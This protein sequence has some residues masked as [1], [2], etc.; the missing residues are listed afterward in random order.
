MP[1]YTKKYKKWSLAGSKII[2][3]NLIWTITTTQYIIHCRYLCNT[4]QV[5]LQKEIRIVITR[6]DSSHVLL[7][8]WSSTSLTVSKKTQLFGSL[9][10]WN[11]Q[12]CVTTFP[13]RKTREETAL[14]AHH[15]GKGYKAMLETV[16]SEKDYS[17]VFPGVNAPTISPQGRSCNALTSQT[18]Q[19]SV[20]VHNNKSYFYLFLYHK[21]SP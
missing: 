8:S 11:I 9:L 18:P 15:S 3:Y 13:R 7:I 6:V 5:R 14:A 2:T 17:L 12:V 1:Q 10:V 19:R 21:G 16:D 4:S 20:K